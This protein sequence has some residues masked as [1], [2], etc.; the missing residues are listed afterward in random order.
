MIQSILIVNFKNCY[1]LIYRY[2]ALKHVNRVR[3]THTKRETYLIKIIWY[4]NEKRIHFKML[5]LSYF[6]KV[7]LNLNFKRKLKLSTYTLFEMKAKKTVPINTIN[8][9]CSGKCHNTINF[10]YDSTKLLIP[11]RSGWKILLLVDCSWLLSLYYI[12]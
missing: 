7:S 10:D 5:Y 4:W 12:N 3:E 2:I 1:V 9:C 6:L 11:D 8:R